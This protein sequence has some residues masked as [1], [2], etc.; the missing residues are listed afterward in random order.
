MKKNYFFLSLLLLI[1]GIAH[2]QLTIQ[3]GATFLI[4]SGATV[5]VQG[6]ISSQ[7]DIQ[8]PGIVLMNGTAVQNLSMNGFSIQNLQV[9][10]STNVV[11]GSNALI[12]TNLQFLAGKLQTGNFDL[13]LANVAT[14][15]GAAAGQFVETNGT[16]HLIKLVNSNLSSYN[17]PLGYNSIYTPVALTTS[18]TYSGASVTVSSK[19]AASPNKPIRST[20]FLKT[21][22]SVNRSG[23]TGSVTAAAQYNDASDITGTESVMRG[24][25]WDGTNWSLSG[26]SI[27]TSTNQVTATITGSNDIYAMNRF[28]YL[29]AKA[30]L[31]G[32][33]ISGTTISGTPVMNENLR[34]TGILPTSDPYRTATYSSNFTHVSN[35]VPEVA[36]VTVFNSQA[37]TR[38][39]IVDWVFVELRNTTVSPGNTILQTRSALL[40][41]DGDI[42]EIDGVNPLYFKDID[43]GNFTIAIRHRNHLGLSSDPATVQ[44]AL[45]EQTPPLLDFTIAPDAQLFGDANAFTIVNSMNMLWAGDISGNGI[46]RYQGSNGP[47]GPNDRVVLLT[48]LGNNES[49]VLTS[50]QRGDVNLNGFTRYQGSNGPTGPNDR[51]FILT[52]VLGNNESAIKTKQLPN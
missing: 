52:N 33:Y 36:D 42:V 10:N 6:D 17:M 18:G 28:L 16:G 37:D 25:T 5:A 12:G 41:R 8:G 47:T 30:F 35:T 27:N 45:N 49:A 38:N 21:Y 34:A 15:S 32:A 39:N 13:Q 19:A 2:S 20:D 48:D 40:Q 29:K 44:K 26:A 50:Y 51:I 31:Q 1:A 14:T 9:S 46:V 3:S 43:A 4:Q 11:L 22:W 23:I 24:F 7:A